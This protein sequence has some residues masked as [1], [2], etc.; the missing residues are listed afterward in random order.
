MSKLPDYETVNNPYLLLR[1]CADYE[2]V[3]C[4]MDR[5]PMMAKVRFCSYCANDPI[6]GGYEYSL[7]DIV[8]RDVVFCGNGEKFFDF[9]EKH[10][11]GFIKPVGLRIEK[12]WEEHHER[13]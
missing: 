11:V 4:L 2:V 1:L 9:V 13:I 6:T 7:I 3:L 5:R 8:K 12:M 10:N